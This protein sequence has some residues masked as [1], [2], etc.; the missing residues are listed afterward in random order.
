M[1]NVL[2]YC[3]ECGGKANPYQGCYIWNVQLT[4]IRGL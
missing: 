1:Y 3:G 4:Q 2:R